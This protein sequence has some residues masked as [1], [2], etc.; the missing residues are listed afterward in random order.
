[1]KN[2]QLQLKLG[3]ILLKKAPTT[4]YKLKTLH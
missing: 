1:M 3:T 2:S 4:K